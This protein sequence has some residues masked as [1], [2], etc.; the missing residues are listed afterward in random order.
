MYV[1]GSSQCRSTNKFGASGKDGSVIYVAG[2]RALKS[3]TC[4]STSWKQCLCAWT[5]RSSPAS[6]LGLGDH[7]LCCQFHG[8]FVEFV[9]MFSRPCIL[10]TIAQLTRWGSMISP[11][12][13]YGIN[14]K[15]SSRMR[16][17]YQQ[18][19]WDPSSSLFGVFV[20]PCA[21]N[22]RSCLCL[23]NMCPQL[24]REDELGM[25]YSAIVRNVSCDML[26]IFC[27]IVGDTPRQ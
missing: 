16:P 23:C 4:S 21:W 13:R 3:R 18:R 5:G 22:V 12:V 6:R 1:R 10:F 26:S 7:L 11:L 9:A 2:R 24:L 14:G 20:R 19:L 8:V 25:S 17:L 15:M 27:L